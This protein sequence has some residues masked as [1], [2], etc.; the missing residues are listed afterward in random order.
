[1]QPGGRHNVDVIDIDGGTDEH[2]AGP[3]RRHAHLLGK[4]L[5]TVPPAPLAKPPPSLGSVSHRNHRNSTPVPTPLV[6][7]ALAHA[8]TAPELR[9]L[10]K[11]RWKI[12]NKMTTGRQPRTLMA[13]IWFH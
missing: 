12:R 7:A 5:V 11:C 6:P 10:T 4:F 8:F 13:I 3:P 1:M 2:R 9:P